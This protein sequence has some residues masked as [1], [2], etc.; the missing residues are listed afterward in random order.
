M[1]VLFG[2]TPSRLRPSSL[3]LLLGSSPSP[4][5]LVFTP[6]LLRQFT[7]SLLYFLL[8]ALILMREEGYPCV[9]GGDLW[10]CNS[11]PKVDPMG[12]LLSFVKARKWFAC[13][14]FSSLPLSFLLL[15]SPL[16]SHR[17]THPSLRGPRSVPRLDPRGRCRPRRLRDGRLQRYRAGREEDA[18][19]W[20]RRAQG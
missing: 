4:V 6:P 10:G 8:D 9:F 17:W 11:E 19:S 20:R 15:T 12:Q 13:K 16:P 3:P 18:G 1:V 2:Q 5:C 14:S 7:D